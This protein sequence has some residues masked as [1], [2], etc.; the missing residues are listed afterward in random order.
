[1]ASLSA[2]EEL[3]HV[4]QESTNEGESESSAFASKLCYGCLV[5]FL[6]LQGPAK[7]TKATSADPASTLHKLPTYSVAALN[8]MK[9]S[10]T[11]HID[12]PEEGF[13]H[14]RAE[15]QEFLL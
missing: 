14:L 5:P 15:I 9:P 13:T 7:K 8:D 2:F 11:T 10:S 1:V 4:I 3:D 12:K 6:E